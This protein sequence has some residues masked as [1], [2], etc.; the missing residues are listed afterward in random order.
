MPNQEPMRTILLNLGVAVAYFATG[1]LGLQVPYYGQHVTLVW[2]PTAIALAAIAL[3]GPTVIPGIFLGGFS[4]NVTLEPDLP[5]PSA[6]IAIGNTLAPSLTGVVLVRWYAFRPQLDR[7]R[8]AFAYL[9]VG[10]LGTGLITATLGALWLCA[11]GDA[12]WGDYAIVWLTWFG[13][14]AA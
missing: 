1:W 14:E 2:A 9:G 4:L 11:F 10:V 7:L 5:G 3:A 13:G 12:P 8:D 6:L